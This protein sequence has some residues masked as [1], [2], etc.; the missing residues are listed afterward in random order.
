MLFIVLLILDKGRILSGST[1]A[2]SRRAQ[3]QASRRFHREEWG[4]A[5][6][7]SDVEPSTTKQG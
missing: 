5:E 7:I 6:V 1:T 4:T 2:H 3:T